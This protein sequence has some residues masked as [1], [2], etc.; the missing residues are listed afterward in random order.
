MPFTALELENIANQVLPFYLKNQIW[1]Q[2]IQDKPLMK[3][4][5]QKQKKYPGGKDEIK[6]NV[7]G[8]Y[9]TQ[10]MGYEHDDT[11]V[12]RN[13]ANVKQFSYTT[14]ELHAGISLTFSELKKAGISVTDSLSGEKTT[15]HSDQE[16]IQISNLFDDKLEDMD[17]GSSKSFNEILWRDG[18]QDS[19]VFAGL[20]SVIVD[21]PTSG[22][23]AGIDRASNSWWRNRA[24]VGANKISY[25][26]ANQTL[27]RRLRQ[28]VRQLRRY[29]GK[30]D[31]ILCGSQ[32]LEALELE[33]H[34]KGT[35]TQEGFMK[36]GS[37]D[38]GMAD[39][40]MRGVGQFMYDPTLDDLGY[41]ARAYFVDTRHTY[42]M[43]MEG[44][45][46]KPHAPARPA[47]KYVLYR[48]VTWTGTLVCRK[49]N[50]NAVYQVDTTGL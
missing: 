22:V 6:G 38:I 2:T 23:A 35:Y 42:I 26:A 46:M 36:A 11:V 39:I 5:R 13:P 15:S 9:T 47:E 49:M 45:D 29:G 8:D 18:A 28:E 27:T 19:K 21:T 4:M 20:L 25:S 3:L 33:V 16:A 30:P 24:L 37:T 40:R 17:E 43:V 50:A 48:A 7:K 10:F 14:K 41:Q 1:S 34:E 32:F 31:L 12:Y 44:E